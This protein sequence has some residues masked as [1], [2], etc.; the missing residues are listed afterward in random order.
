MA[1]SQDLLSKPAALFQKGAY[2]QAIEEAQKLKPSESIDQG[3]VQFFIGTSFAKLQQFD[4]AIPHYKKSVALGYEPEQIYFDLGQAYYASQKIDEADAAFKKSILKKFKVAASAYY[5][6]YIRQ[7]KEDRPGA[8]DYYNRI[9]KLSKDPENV[10]QAALFQLAEMEFDKHSEEKNKQRKANLLDEYVLPLYEKVVDFSADSPLGEQAKQKIAT[11]ESEISAVND[12]MVNGNPTPRKPYTLRLSQDFSY[13]TNVITEADEALIQ[14]SEKD[15]FISKTGILAKYQ[16]NIRKRFSVVP[17]FNGSITLHSRRS[18]PKVYQNDNIS[19][20]PAVRTKW[21]HFSGGKA[22]TALFDIEYN[23]MLRDYEQQHKWPYYTRYINFVVGERVTWFATGSTTLKISAKFAE[24][25]NPDRNNITPAVSLGQ[26]IKIAGRWDLQNTLSADYLR[27]R[28]DF[29]DEINY[30]LSQNITFP[31]L[32]EKV[33]FSPSLS[34]TIKDTLKQKG[35][36]GNE[37]LLNPSFGLSREILA[38]LDGTFDYAFS[39]NYS[40]AKDTYQ[41]TKHEIKLGAAYS[42]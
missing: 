30:K 22:A 8:T 37:F 42:F 20:S 5:V 2:S 41:Y 36:R 16:W 18:Y 34:M 10:K 40:K 35:S 21:E 31:K 27:A 38:A 32:F 23:L 7:M 1:E 4:K 25:Y 19:L 39:K 9:Q 11:I 3:K 28:D 26:N 33:D 14:V 13:D 29:N 6:A 12:R 24:N 17:E 15:S